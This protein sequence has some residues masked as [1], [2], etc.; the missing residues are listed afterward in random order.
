MSKKKKFKFGRKVYAILHGGGIAKVCAIQ[1]HD[2]GS[3]TIASKSRS[4]FILDNDRLYK[5]FKKA[6]TAVFAMHSER[7]SGMHRRIAEL[8][9]QLEQINSQSK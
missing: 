7:D 6:A 3:T 2:N 1:S 4:V 9:R 5:S 8:E